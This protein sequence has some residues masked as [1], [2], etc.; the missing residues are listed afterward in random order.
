MFERL[1][2]AVFQVPT[3][4]FETGVEDDVYPWRLASPSVFDGIAQEVDDLGHRS[5]KV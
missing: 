4:R 3:R 1:A 5:R 2:R